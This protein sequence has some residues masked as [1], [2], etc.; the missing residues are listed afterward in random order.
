MNWIKMFNGQRPSEIYSVQLPVTW[1]DRIL[2]FIAFLLLIAMWVL[3]AFLWRLSEG[4]DV[5]LHIRLDGEVDNVGDPLTLIII[6]VAWTFVM[7]LLAFSAYRPR[8]INPSIRI[9][10]LKQLKLVVTQVRG[11]NIIMGIMGI[12][13]LLSMVYETIVW[14]IIP[15]CLLLVEVLVF[16]I[17]IRRTGK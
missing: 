1:T 7:L 13:L 8:L 10:T 14:V 15:T 9:T 5:A 12:C 16:S 6:T 3:A 17:L 4:K 11:M 2:E